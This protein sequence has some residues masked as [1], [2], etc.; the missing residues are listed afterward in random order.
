MI[1][2]KP[3]AIPKLVGEGFENEYGE[4]VERPIPG[5]SERKII[6]IPTA[7]N[8]PAAMAPHS[9]AVEELSTAASGTR[10]DSFCNAIV[11]DPLDRWS[12]LERTRLTQVGWVNPVP[13]FLGA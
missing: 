11:V 5:P 9:T 13:H 8:A 12:G 7:A 2:H 3:A 1:S 4:T 10:T 6:E